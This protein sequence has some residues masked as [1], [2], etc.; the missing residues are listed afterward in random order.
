MNADLDGE[1]AEPRGVAG[2]VAGLSQGPSL[3]LTSRI[4]ATLP[5]P[6]LAQR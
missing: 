2:K 4:S 6:S 5:Q 1:R 3:S